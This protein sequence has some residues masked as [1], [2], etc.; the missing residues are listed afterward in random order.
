MSR[1][2]DD[3]WLARFEF[4]D[5]NGL[6]LYRFGRISSPSLSPPFALIDWTNTNQ[7][8]YHQHLF[9]FV[10]RVTMHSSC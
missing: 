2:G 9:P 3:A 4:F 6:L 5:S 10:A 7:L 8:F 1:S